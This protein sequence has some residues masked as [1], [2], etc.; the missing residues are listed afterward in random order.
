MP[1]TRV[2]IND[3]ERDDVLRLAR[4]EEVSDARLAGRPI[5]RVTLADAIRGC[6]VEGLED[7]KIRVGEMLADPEEEAEED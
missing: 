4:L 2:W 5:R 1:W 3:D 7:M 6:F